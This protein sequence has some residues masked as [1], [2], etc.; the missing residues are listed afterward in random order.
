MRCLI[1]GGAGFVGSHLAEALL[2]EM[3]EVTVLDDLS[4]GSIEN[5]QHLRGNSHFH[6]VI[7]T[8]M[9]RPLLAELVDQSDVIFHLAAAVGVRLII[10]SPVR[11]IETN[12]RPTELLLELATKKRK[13]VLIASTSEVYGKSQKFPFSEGDD[14]VIGSPDKGR[15]SYACSKAI[16]EFLALAYWREKKLP[17]IIVRLF[18]TIGPRQT[19]Q[20]GMVV[21][22]FIRQA[23]AGETLT[24][25]GDGRQSRC[26][27]WVGD[28]VQAMI[29]L[30][31]NPNAPGKVFNVGSD[32][33]ITI[34]ELAER[35]KRVTS[36][37]SRIQLIPYH[38]AYEPGFEDMPRRIP[39]LSRIGH[40]IGYR[41]TKA[42]DEI[43][44]A[45]AAPLR[46]RILVRAR[47]MSGTASVS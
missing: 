31:K 28:V 13:T 29:A 34:L 11:T 14:L 46:E 32:E 39:D 23:M 42:L 47:S 10:E 25:F 8:M 18:N 37:E 12:I 35:V 38:E 43:L 40:L 4:T 44:L 24:V 1:T 22:T 2:G 16:D 45:I 21:P 41:P 3:S 36:S 27:G 5:I 33:E 7:D 15:W 6:L 26:F 17:T 19:G 9:N 30:V 20:Y